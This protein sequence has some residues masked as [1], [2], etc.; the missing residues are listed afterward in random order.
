MTAAMAMLT[1]LE[2]IRSTHPELIADSAP[3]GWGMNRFREAVKPPAVTEK[4]TG[5]VQGAIAALTLAAECGGELDKPMYKTACD[6]LSN[7]IR[8]IK[9]HDTK[10]YLKAIPPSASDYNV[11]IA[12]LGL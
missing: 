5:A 8:C 11:V 3:P 6:E 4:P 10:L 2:S 9:D 1:C 12:A 7:L